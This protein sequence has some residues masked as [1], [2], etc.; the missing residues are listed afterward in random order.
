MVLANTHPQ[1][2]LDLARQ[3]GLLRAS[4][5]DAIEAPR[6]A[7]NGWPSGRS[8]KPIR[9]PSIGPTCSQALLKN[10]WMVCGGTREITRARLG[11]SP[12]PLSG[13]HRRE[14]GRK[15]RPATLSAFRNFYP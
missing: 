5:L 6:V 12:A 13:D 11:R 1:R 4:D 15:P 8:A 10:L 7:P 14:T 2:V 9:Q 3:K